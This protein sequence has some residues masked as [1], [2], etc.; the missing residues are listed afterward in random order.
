MVRELREVGQFLLNDWRTLVIDLLLGLIVLGIACAWSWK[1][2]LMLF[3]VLSY[4]A[5]V[6]IIMLIALCIGFYIKEKIDALFT[7]YRR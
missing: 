1:L 5:G 2:A 4:A 7:R 3:A 6:V